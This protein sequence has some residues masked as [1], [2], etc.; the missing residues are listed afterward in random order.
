[1][2]DMPNPSEALHDGLSNEYQDNPGQKAASVLAVAVQRI[3]Q[4]VLSNLPG[5]GDEVAEFLIDCGPGYRLYVERDGDK[6][7]I[8]LPG[9]SGPRE[10]SDNKARSANL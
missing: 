10:F 9:G 3:E 5:F 7:T 6:L 4:G 2:M 1:M 8:L